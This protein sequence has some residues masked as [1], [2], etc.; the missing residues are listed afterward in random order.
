MGHKYRDVQQARQNAPVFPT[1]SQ[2]AA[3]ASQHMIRANST[4]FSALASA[5]QTSGHFMVHKYRDVQPARQNAPNTAS[6]H[7]T[8]A[9]QHVINLTDSSAL[10]SVKQT[11]EHFAVHK[12]RDVQQARQNAPVFSTASQH[13][14]PVSQHV[15]RVGTSQHVNPASASQPY[16]SQS[17]CLDLADLKSQK[18]N[19]RISQQTNESKSNT[20]HFSSV[21]S[22]D[23]LSGHHQI[24]YRTKAQHEK[25]PSGFD[26]LSVCI[27]QCH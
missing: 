2:H 13:A 25:N 24:H 6:Q 3:P 20:R 4:D 7:A 12:Y 26:F 23:L 27:V 9:S 11:S 10:A 8:P 16:A 17:Q 18:M 19:V 22:G 5:K 14:V 15:I 1:A 21:K